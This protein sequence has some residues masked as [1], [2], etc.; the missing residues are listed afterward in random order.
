MP[1]NWMNAPVDGWVMVPPL[2]SFMGLFGKTQKRGAPDIPEK[3]WPLVRKKNLSGCGGFTIWSWQ[4]E[5]RKKSIF[6]S[7]EKLSKNVVCLKRTRGV[8]KKICLSKLSTSWLKERSYFIL[9][10]LK[11]AL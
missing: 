7:A 5:F 6:E 3:G 11:N 8:L 2:D 10:P 1:A 4:N 9:Y